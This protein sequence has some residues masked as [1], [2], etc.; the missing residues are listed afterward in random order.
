MTRK[1]GSCVS[2]TLGILGFFATPA[3]AVSGPPSIDRETLVGQ[4]LHPGEPSEARV[5][6]EVNPNGLATYVYVE[7]GETGESKYGRAEQYGA[8]TAIQGIGSGESDSTV[9]SYLKGL[10]TGDTYF[11]RVAASNAMGEVKGEPMS[12]VVPS[13][14]TPGWEVHAQPIP[15]HMV[16]GRTG[17]IEVEAYNTGG[18]ASTAGAI[19]TDTLPAGLTAV[20]QHEWTCSSGTPV[21]CSEPLA[22]VPAGAQTQNAKYYESI[23]QGVSYVTTW[24]QVSVEAGAGGTGVNRATVAGGGASASASFSNPVT[25]SATPAGFGVE[26]FDGWF[27][28]ANGTPDTQAGSHP[29]EAT[30]RLDFN[31]RNEP[32]AE[33]EGRL[34][35]EVAGGEAR[36]VEAVLPPGFVGDPQAVPQ[37]TRTQFDRQECPAST[38]IGVN[39]LD[40]GQYYPLPV[41]V[42][43]LVPP[44]G[45]PA[46]F[47]FT[48]VGIQAFLDAEVRSGGNDGLTEHIDNAPQE[49][50]ESSSLTLW[51]VPAEASHNAERVGPG[52]KD[53]CPSGAALLPL[54][55]LPTSCEGPLTTTVHISAWENSS[56]GEASYESNDENGAPLGITGCEALSFSP[57]ISIA[58][59]TSYADTPA[60]LS[61]ELHVPQEALLD[62]EG[63]STADVKDTK[64]VL[65]EG[66]VINPGQAVG[67]A[68][69]QPSQDG[70]ERLP[71]GEEDNGPASCP[72]AS[73]VGTDEVETPLLKSKLQGS[74][75]VLQSDPPDL[76]LLITAYGEGVYLKLVGNVQLN[77]ATGQLTT[78]FDETPALP[79]SDFKLSFNGGAQAALDTPTQCG[80][81]TTSADFTPWATPFVPD[82]LG[83][84]NFQIADGPGG[85]GC[86]PSPLP[87]SPQLVA[88]A[89]TDQAGGFTSFSMLLQRG[90]GQQRIDRLQFKAPEGLTGFLSKVPLC[91][92]AQAEANQCPTASKIG[93]TVVESGPG[94]YPLVVPEPGQEPAPI[95]LTEGY[96]GAPFGLSIVVPLRVGPFTLP[97]QRVRAKIEVNPLTA[98]L[99]V[100]TDPLPQVVAGVPTDLRE[101][102]AVVE[103]PEFMVNPT[104]CDPEEFTGTAYGTPPVGE[105]GAGAEA[106]IS[107]HFQ[108]GSC[109]S[110]EFAPKLSVSTSANTSKADGASL[111]TKVSYP[112]VP[113]GADA[114]IA[115]VK[116]E[117]P[118]QLPSRLSTLQKACTSAQFE[119]NPADCPAASRIGYA[120]VHTPLLPVPLEGPA[121]FVSH[122]GEAFP[123][124]TMILQGDGVTIDLVGTTF[125]SKAGVTSTTFKAVPDAPFSTFELTLPEGPYSALTANANLC[126]S[127]LVLPDEFVGQNGAKLDG[128]THI[129]VEGCPNT[130]GVVS[131]TLKGSTVTLRVSVPEA[132]KL[133]ATGS[134]LSVGSKSSEDREVVTLK[135]GARLTAAQRATLK[136][137]PGRKI[138]T[139]LKLRFIPKK[140]KPLTKAVSLNL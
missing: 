57:A 12:F 130:L 135:L 84:S 29:Y 40:L 124:L 20:S 117:L 140:G 78:T 7:Y 109:R 86:P 125:I 19:L 44:S 131:K 96:K 73:K 41:P 79:Y 77:E 108:V 52:C 136:R 15:T 126:N 49:A 139:T 18:N 63:I 132:G 120:V 36:N 93:H 111:T 138:V 59:D 35:S 104:N 103:R 51:G 53:G 54:L 75:Y 26:G 45:V 62:P 1:I 82:S 47:G 33:E 43:N 10:Q 88:G 122:G 66:V 23:P 68:A 58:P 101:V 81:Y 85:G 119:A 24:L 114:D 95:Y 121:I 65:P 46:Q 92:N 94:P 5:D 99:T 56:T 38:Q 105:G 37:C 16:P 89:T 123:S 74:V 128:D 80:T 100:T 115:S 2:L 102:D 55:T 3:L 116:V 34:Q 118:K 42:Y 13:A 22:A 8:Y 106:P 6:A 76:K 27:S 127:D 133:T 129:A 25:F 71:D 91:T 14:G 50:I 28:N 83:S 87:F 134:G 69:C 31:T 97:T 30:T 113:Q 90:D 112:N 39:V 110:L 70:L 72:L 9:T 4:L 17:R 61:V 48:V 11:F 60:G 32:A 98:A 137:H 67:L 107:S 21:T 64:V